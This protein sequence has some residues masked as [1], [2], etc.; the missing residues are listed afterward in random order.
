MHTQWKY[1]CHVSKYIL[2]EPIFFATYHNASMYLFRLWLILIGR[3]QST[4][5]EEISVP[6]VKVHPNRTNILCHVSQCVHASFQ[7]VADF[8]RTLSKY[9]RV[10]VHP[11]NTNMLCHL[12]QCVHVSFLIVADFDRTLSKYTH[13]ENISV[14]RVTVGPNS[15]NIL[16]HISQCVHVSFQV[17]ADFDRTLSKYTHRG[18]ICATCHSTS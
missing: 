15:T 4:H 9:T 13:R 2:T 8:D 1:L 3:Y 17:V 12:S 16:C 14:P 7:V 11:K 6:C 18:N 10:T 5:T